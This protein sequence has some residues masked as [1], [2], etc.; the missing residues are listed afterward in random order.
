[1][2]LFTNKKMYLFAGTIT[3]F[4]VILSLFL[5]FQN[6]QTIAAAILTEA[7][8]SELEEQYKTSENMIYQ[9]LFEGENVPFDQA[10]DTYYL[11]QTT[12]GNWL[13]EDS[14]TLESKGQKLY[15]C[16]DD[17][18]DDL[19][20]AIA[21]GHEF[22]FLVTEEEY[23]AKGKIVFTGLPMMTIERIDELATDIYYCKMTAF[24]PFHN[25]AGLY[26][27]TS[28]YGVFGLR[29]RT[30][31]KFPKKGW[32]LDLLK[33][34][35]DPYKVSLFGLRAD[36]D[37]KL[38]ALYPDATKVREK[39]GI[40]IWNELA[41][42]TDS[43]YDAG[44]NME[45]F[46]LILENDYQGIY[47][48]MEQ[49]DYKQFSMDKTE[50]VIYKSYSWPREG[51][52]DETTV[53]DS[54][55]YCGHLIKTADRD[56]SR[57]LWQPLLEYVGVTGFKSEDLSYNS[58]K[59]FQYIN[60]HMNMDNLLNCDLFIQLLYAYD[61]KYKNLYINADIKEDGY[62]LW[63]VPWDLN[64]SF[65][66]RYINKEEDALT[67]YNLEWA[68]EIMPEFMIT[69]MLLESGN[70]EFAEILNEKWEELQETV[71]CLENVQKI[72]ETQMNLLISSGAFARDEVRWPDGPHETSV[73]KI[74]EFHDARLGFL[75]EHYGSYL[76][77][78]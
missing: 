58:E 4:L 15:W 38:N 11:P 36:D 16:E 57:E 59:I 37:W 29:G 42:Q 20:A 67:C 78:N 14:F 49:L 73:E 39:I 1:M 65:G 72:A 53:G 43:P 69:E 44:T 5:K 77:E 46:E 40:E 2:N 18:W 28:G 25:D 62:T 71:F 24:D 55:E 52:T 60:E 64:Y 41:A 66:D 27:V 7:K 21:D 26:E 17:Y 68:N 33:E 12:D 23:I 61:N 50:D 74:L 9:L 75:D 35:G 34:N 32:S 13:K 51:H 48:A 10:K 31:K 63:K 19:N 56:I 8:Q 3:V 30:S 47:G 54:I 6:M 22:A 45:Y 70:R 76:N